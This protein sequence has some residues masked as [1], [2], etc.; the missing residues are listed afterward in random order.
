MP[1]RCIAGSRQIHDFKSHE[2]S[3]PSLGSKGSD[4][5]FYLTRLLFVQGSFS[6]YGYTSPPIILAIILALGAVYVPVCVAY[7]L[8]FSPL[9]KF[10]GSSLAALTSWYDFFYDCVQRGRFTFKI[11]E[12]HQRYGKTT[13]SP[14]TDPLPSIVSSI[15]RWRIADQIGP[16]V[17]IS[18]KEIH[19]NDPLLSDELYSFKAKRDRDYGVKRHFGMDDA[20]VFTASHDLYRLRR[21]ALALKCLATDIITEHALAKSYDLLY[22]L[23]FSKDWYKAQQDGG[24]FTLFAKYFLWLIPL[25]R[26]V[27]VRFV[28]SSNTGVGPGFEKSNR[29]IL[30]Q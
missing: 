22:T 27:P 17:L 4:W 15:G 5:L 19:I 7:R 29:V 9:A 30:Q 28:A 3:F 18:P 16:T 1:N 8:Y 21:A 14:G 12:L 23:Y 26:R 10:P 24:Q 13:L 25:L 20:T 6:Q 11:D 2:H